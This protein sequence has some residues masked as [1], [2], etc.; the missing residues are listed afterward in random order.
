MTLDG[1]TL[2]ALTLELHALMQ[3]SRVRQVYHPQPHLIKLVL[4]L[5]QARIEQML[6]I[7]CGEPPL[8]HL[9]RAPLDN[10]LSPSS[11]CML[12]RKHLKNGVV[13][14]VVQDG[15][16]RIAGVWV[17]RAERRYQLRAE[18][19]GRHGNV[20]LLAPSP[21]GERFKVL[22][23]ALAYPSRN[24][25]PGADYVPPAQQ[26]K[27]N[28]LAASG[29]QFLALAREEGPL[30]RFLLE[31]VEG[32]GPRLAKEL[33]LR[34]QVDPQLPVGQLE[35]ERLRAVW[36]A[37]GVMFSSVEREELE[38]C[39]YL[40]EGKPFEAAPFRLK[41]YE[42]LERLPAPSMCEAF[43]RCAEEELPSVRDDALRLS[44][45][46][47]LNASVKKA[48]TAL[49]HVAADLH[50]AQAFEQIKLEAD[51]IMIN[52][53]ALQAGEPGSWVDPQSGKAVTVKLDPRLSAVENAQ[54]RYERYK[55]LRRGVDKL[56]ARQADLRL[57]LEYLQ[58]AQV[59][60]EQAQ[61]LQ[62]LEALAV[63]LGMKP[64]SQ[65][66]KREAEPLRP[67]RVECEGYVILVGRN[68]RQNDELT[69]NA[70]AE[71]L[72]LH[73]RQRPGS[74]VVIQTRGKPEAV[75]ERVRLRAAQLAAYYSKG[76]EATKV[77]VICTRAKFLKKPKGAKPGLVLV[78]KEEQVLA[79]APQGEES[80]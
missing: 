18:L 7:S 73:A 44:V 57:E 29:E 36:E 31:R 2:R 9:G 51:L 40:K 26:N 56:K 6:L 42:G 28:P 49:D 30:W 12:L 35:A 32:I 68:S 52:L 33:A 78:S 39:V 71:D 21:A 8:F 76:R 47:H 66:S 54:R 13:E 3:N 38:P 4:W 65:S 70:H 22:G 43:A 80:A 64:A 14:G 41:L 63:E 74:H 75:P 20:L 53:G 34:A 61:S 59:Q 72:W 16:E 58:T 55:K 79:V 10:P 37:A 23:A 15:L 5:P 24:V 1:L 62:E 11:F 67:R 25:H 77:P 27:L 46:K 50:R 48:N 69:R 60:A 17:R 19:L 45:L